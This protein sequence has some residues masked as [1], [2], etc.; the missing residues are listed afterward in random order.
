MEIEPT[1]LVGNT[2]NIDLASAEYSQPPGI[3]VILGNNI[4][5]PL[6]FGVDVVSDSAIDFIAALGIFDDFGNIT[7][8]TGLWGFPNADFTAAPYFD[9]NAEYLAIDYNG[10]A[11]PIHNF[12]IS[13]TFSPDGSAIGGAQFSGLGDTQDLGPA[14]LPNGDADTICNILEP[15]GAEC[16]VC[17]PGSYSTHEGAK[18]CSVCEAGK[19]SVFGNTSLGAIGCT[20]CLAGTIATSG[21]G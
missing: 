11:I 10:I 19:H 17:P 21:Q 9:A 14:F 3:D 20:E 6:L 5:Q 16:E 13:G 4:D 2:Y 7:Q 1:G 18:K 8:S 15:L 12:N